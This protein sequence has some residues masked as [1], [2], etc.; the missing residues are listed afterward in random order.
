MKRIKAYGKNIIWKKN[1]FGENL[2]LECN[3]HS[4]DCNVIINNFLSTMVWKRH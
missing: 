3:I 4:Y 2:I 1:K